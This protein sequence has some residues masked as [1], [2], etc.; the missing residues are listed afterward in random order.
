MTFKLSD[1]TL[2]M[3]LIILAIVEQ[4]K[5]LVK[6]DLVKMYL[7]TQSEVL[8]LSFSIDTAWTDRYKSAQKNDR[9]TDSTEHIT[10]PYGDDLWC[11]VFNK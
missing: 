5:I 1:I 2:Q 10:Y 7:K 8:G 3:T 6:V 9:Q 11:F 4:K